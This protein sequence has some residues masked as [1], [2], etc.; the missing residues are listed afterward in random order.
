[1]N[2]IAL[3]GPAV[4]PVSLAEMKAHLRLDGP[5]EDALVEALIVAGRVTV[6]RQTRLALIE[7]SWC[8]ALQTWP[9]D[10]SVPLPLYPV[11]AIEEVRLSGEGGQDV[12]LSPAHYRLEPEGD[13]TR[14]VVD[15]AAP[16]PAG[17]PTRIEIDFACG[18]GSAPETV[19]EPLRLAIRRLVAYWFEHRG[20]ERKPGQPSVPPDVRA[21]IAPFARPRLV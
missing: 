1:M 8:F 15:A 20:D 13:V 11:R 21:L 12:V 16:A 5:D 18:F 10:L 7:Q 17:L 4:E 2:P 14:L 6:E 19:P 9:R 3:V